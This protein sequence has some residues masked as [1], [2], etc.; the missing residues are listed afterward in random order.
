MAM[1][2]RGKPVI[3]S[4]IHLVIETLNHLVNENRMRSVF[5]AVGN[6]RRV[7]F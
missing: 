1:R 5:Q 7:F 6:L 3:R 2:G 4:L